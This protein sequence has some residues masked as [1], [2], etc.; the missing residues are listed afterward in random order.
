[1]LDIA[2]VQP[3]SDQL[4]MGFADG[5]ACVALVP[6]KK[7]TCGQVNLREQAHHAMHSGEAC[8]AAK[9]ARPRFAYLWQQLHVDEH[10]RDCAGLMPRRN[11]WVAIMQ[12]HNLDAVVPHTAPCA[13]MLRC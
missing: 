7:R 4:D 5:Y 1:M 2:S 8:R 3:G 10:D 13:I 11:C 6:C 9:P 12:E